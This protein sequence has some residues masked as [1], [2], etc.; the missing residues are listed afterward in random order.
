MKIPQF[1][2]ILFLLFIC[3]LQTSNAQ[4]NNPL[5]SKDF[6][7]QK[8]W[9]DSIYNSMSLQE[10][11]GQLFMVDVFSNKG[12]REIDK[13]REMITEQHIGGIIFS[14]GGPLQQATLN[15]EFQELAKTPLLIGMDAEWGLAMRLDSTFALPWNMT[16]GAIQDLKLIEEAGAAISRNSKRL[17]VHI[18]FAP[19][20]DINTNPDN[21]IIGNRSFGEEKINV[22]L[23][24]VS[25]MR[26]MHKEGI[27]S[28]AKHFPGHGDTKRDSH[29]FLPIINFLKGRLDS[30]EFY[31]FKKLIEEGVSSIMIAH[32]NVPSLE[33]Q[34]NVPSSLSKSIVTDLLKK[35]LKFN[36]LV[37]TDALNMKGASN[38]KNPGEID[39][40]AFM[41]GNDILLMSEDV[42]KATIKI[43][44][45]YNDGTITEERL[46]H[47]VRKILFTKYKAGLNHYKPVEKDYLIDELNTVKDKVLYDKLIENAITIIKNDVGIMPLKELDTKR[48]AYVNFGDD[49]GAPF[50]YQL[51]KYAKV[52]WVKGH[53]LKELLDKLKDYNQVII[54]YHKSNASPW[55][56][57]AFDKTEL[58]WIHEIARN[59]STILNV[60]TIPYALR[61]LNSS[62]NLEGIVVSYQN[63]KAAQE[64]SAQIIFGALDAKGRLP[65]SISEEFPVGT[66]YYTKSI[67]RL[68]YGYPEAVGMNSYKL[69][70]ID[71]LINRAIDEGM[72]PGVQLV[73]ARKGKVI[74]QRNAGYHTYDKNI[75]VTDSSLYDLASLTKILA[76]LPMIMELEEAGELKFSSKLGDLMPIFKGSNKQN[77]KLQ[78]M[79]MHYARLTPWIPFYITTLDRQ[80]KQRSKDYYREEPAIGFN[81]RVA[82]KMYMRD[83]IGDT[84]LKII[85][86]SKLEPKLAY[87]YSDL[88]FYIMKYFI[89]DHYNESLSTLTKD[90]FY[91]PLGASTITFTP[92]D[93]V[94]SHR[95]V[96]TEEDKLWRNQEVLGYVHDQGAAMQGGIGGHAG[97][98]SN[99]ID[100]AKI[101]QLYLNGGTYGGKRYFKQETLDKFNTCYY[102]EQNVRRGVGFDKPQLGSSGPTCG[103]VSLSSF[104]HTGFTGTLA[105]ADPDKEIVYIF[106]SNRTYPD[107]NNRKLIREDI[108]EKIQSVIY[109]SIDF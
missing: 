88:P 9:V 48:I 28:S 62:S 89:E 58:T 79:L 22:T 55:A 32:L 19:V 80:T 104:G 86:D 98:F 91:N 50:Y 103:C 38:Y 59:N 100:V 47:S 95:I 64:K 7:E 99:A 101:M 4:N 92:L 65:V 72:T 54:G 71:S 63:S 82:D 17:G 24:A 5:I 20:V 2:S 57:Y 108:R 67:D 16:M 43:L 66:G 29:K 49:D 11:V 97:L 46:A 40:A 3:A 74:F 42:K 69:Q 6:K 8:I 15:N 34:E 53:T 102:C 23:K 77:I 61:D 25:F 81:L 36:G 78:D 21:P 27:L 30:V 33:V 35:E 39:L 1:Y 75:K 26:G 105:W 14:K 41:A 12:K 109:E 90:H 44:D 10:K 106:L 13:I 51:A 73:I 83:D 37:F 84:I 60:F 93:Y 87:K 31:P 76:S 107:V 68:S 45:A 56:K 96:P 52:D 18:N 85:R 70:K 94:D